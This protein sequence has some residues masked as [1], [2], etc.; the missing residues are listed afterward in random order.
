MA[1]TALLLMAGAGCSGKS[2][3]RQG[4]DSSVADTIAEPTA[5]A[6]TLI[7]LSGGRIGPVAT[8]TKDGEWPDAEPGLYDTVEPM[9]G[10]DANVWN[11]YLD[12]EC[13]FSALDYGEGN[14]D[15]ICLASQKVTAETDNGERVALG[16][17]FRKVLAIPGVRAEWASE[18]D[19]GMWYW[20]TGDLWFAP[21]QEGLPPSL[22]NLLYSSES[23]PSANDFPTGIT[24]GYIGTGL[25]F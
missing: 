11:F 1:L 6:D 4:A 17:D 5:Q 22:V 8:G 21:T 10:G 9:P 7:L 3:S 15:L 19:S 25:P 2:D 24:I 16:E 13:L 18:D 20:T 23:A 14:V 12:G